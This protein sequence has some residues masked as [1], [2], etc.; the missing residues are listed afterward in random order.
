MEFMMADGRT[1]STEQPQ[2]L[3]RIMGKAAEASPADAEHEVEALVTSVTNVLVTLGENP[4]IRWGWLGGGCTWMVMVQGLAACQH[5]SLLA[6]QPRCTA[7][8][9]LPAAAARRLLRHCMLHVQPQRSPSHHIAS[10][11]L[12][13][14]SPLYPRPSSPTRYRAARRPEEEGAPVARPAAEQVATKLYTSLQGNTALPGKES[15]DLLVLDRCG[16]RVARCAADV[17]SCCRTPL[18]Q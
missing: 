2:A 9:T 1:V 16:G 17:L 6:C 14:S 5:A 11:C 3:L 7:M 4:A 13:A 18:V 12:T 8:A 10:Q 15:C